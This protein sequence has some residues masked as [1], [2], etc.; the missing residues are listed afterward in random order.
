[1]IKNVCKDEDIKD[2]YINANELVEILER[3]KDARL[4]KVNCSKSALI[5]LNAFNYCINIIKKL[6]HY[7]L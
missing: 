6:N 2:Y 3:L 7:E 5:E 4:K 1:M